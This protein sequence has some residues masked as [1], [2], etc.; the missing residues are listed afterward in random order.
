M[1]TP[2]TRILVPTDFSELS[3]VALDYAE[4]LAERCGA[5]LHVLHVIEDRFLLGA[6]SSE[7]YVPDVPALR[8]ALVTSAESELATFV[9][10]R[11]RN[12]VRVTTEVRVGNAATVICEVAGATARDLG[13]MGTH[14]RTG[15]AHLLLGSVAE[16]VVHTAPCP[17][18]TVRGD[19]RTRERVFAPM[20]E[21]GAELRG[22]AC[23]G[24]A[25]VAESFIRVS[26]S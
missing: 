18:L 13:V 19:A 12:A 23:V 24:A 10:D 2:F 8:A 15:I 7:I 11:V 6:T 4:A 21:A 5:S 16:K 9:A 22:V 14:G 1:S 26:R 3:A 20:A 25:R 17:V